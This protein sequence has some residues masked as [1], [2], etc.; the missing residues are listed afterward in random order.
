ML[1]AALAASPHAL[2]PH[3]RKHTPSPSRRSIWN[4]SGQRPAPT[5]ARGGRATGPPPRP[6]HAGSRP[7]SGG[8]RLKTCDKIHGHPSHQQRHRAAQDL[9]QDPRPSK[10]PAL[11]PKPRPQRFD[12][13]RQSREPHHVRGLSG[14][15]G[16]RTEVHRCGSRCPF[17]TEC[18]QMLGKC[19]FAGYSSPPNA[20][21]QVF[22]SGGRS[23]N[24]RRG[25]ASSR[26]RPCPESRRDF[27]NLSGGL[28]SDAKECSTYHVV[29][30]SDIPRA[31]RCLRRAG[32][33]P[34]PAAAA[35]VAQAPVRA[36]LAASDEPRP[37]RDGQGAAAANI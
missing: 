27:S 3:P 24:G 20:F 30:V 22:A 32:S 8:V 11:G 36:L 33:H 4:R 14:E 17:G 16:R 21:A 19:R 1:R 28:Q 7:R 18:R 23:P 35:P 9:R 34:R 31:H 5:R 15:L 25:A 6:L 29:T 26:G 13:P 37:P 2:A 12:Q 10:A